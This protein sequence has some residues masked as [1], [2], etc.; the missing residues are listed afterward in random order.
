MGNLYRNTLDKIRPDREF[1][2]TLIGMMKERAETPAI[3]DTGNRRVIQ[4]KPADQQ[5]AWVP[6]SNRW[7]G[8]ALSAASVILVLLSLPL[9]LMNTGRP[10]GELEKIYFPVMGWDFFDDVSYKLAENPEQLR[11]I[12]GKDL[13]EEQPPPDTLPVYINLYPSNMDG[14]VN[15]RMSG[16]EVIAILDQVIN[17]MGYTKTGEYE[18]G[19]FNDRSVTCIDPARPEIT[20]TLWGG[21]GGGYSMDFD[22][23]W[24]AADVSPEDSIARQ[25]N[26]FHYAAQKLS[27]EGFAR[28]LDTGSPQPFVVGNHKY[29]FGVE[30]Y[31]PQTYAYDGRGVQ[32]VNRSLRPIQYGIERDGL[33]W[34]QARNADLS[35]PAGD[36]PILTPE[37]AKE[38]LLNGQHAGPDRGFTVTDP[39]KIVAYEIVYKQ[40]EVEIGSGEVG[41][42]A[43]FYKFYVEDEG[44]DMAYSYDMTQEEWDQRG[45]KVY[46]E[47]LVPAVTPSL[48]GYGMTAG[49]AVPEIQEGEDAESY[50]ARLE[51]AGLYAL[52][53]QV[54]SDRPQ[55][56]VLET[57]PVAGE[58]AAFD[59]EIIV[60]ISGGPEYYAGEQG[61][62]YWSN[63][64]YYQPG[65]V[66]DTG[67]RYD[68]RG[69][70][71]LSQYSREELCNLFLQ[72]V[73]TG[74]GETFGRISVMREYD[75]FLWY[76]DN[77]LSDVS[78]KKIVR[79]DG[80][81]VYMLRFTTTEMITEF[82]QS[83]GTEMCLFVSFEWVWREKIFGSWKI[84]GFAT[85]P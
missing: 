42:F 22:P 35:R 47:F 5:T 30:G 21:G 61:P 11:M 76:P 60:R 75:Y 57:V 79:T 38:R 67:K 13:M 71:L 14:M 15:N 43:P 34:I 81:E 69:E 41:Y 32:I 55:G 4:L 23:P 12:I 56:Q 73:E 68:D 82:T 62:E 16:D 74:D 84:S 6:P 18:D 66:W 40:N 58:L 45:L 27:E 64:D 3:P 37:Q 10:S 36:Y 2:N 50:L 44:A 63:K 31:L 59:S 28:L 29:I 39:E 46:Y 65:R 26:K 24:P 51:E 83:G 48:F 80:D 54:R 20:I 70:K 85:S 52:K 25:M 19:M 78:I 49:A 1:K 53:E 72:C 8:I 9:W 7:R 33:R 17:K 77:R